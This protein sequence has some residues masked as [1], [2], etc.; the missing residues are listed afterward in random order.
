MARRDIH[1]DDLDF[2]PTP[3]FVTRALMSFALYGDEWRSTHA[4]DPACGTGDMAHPLQEY[5][6]KVSAS[7]LVDRGFGF[8]HDF[9][10]DDNPAIGEVD[11]IITNPPFSASEPFVRKALSIAKIGIAMLLR[12]MWLEGKSRYYLFREH[13]PESLWQFS[14]RVPL[15]RGKIDFSVPSAMAVCWIVWRKGHTGKPTINWLPPECKTLLTYPGDEHNDL[16][17]AKP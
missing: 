7:D 8:Q 13:P 9:L 16:H 6:G 17:T 4:W 12:T 10:K 15:V 14:G 1:P 3:P 11:W 5:F 2:Y